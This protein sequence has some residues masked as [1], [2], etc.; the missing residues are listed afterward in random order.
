MV[1]KV[2]ASL[3]GA[4]GKQSTHHAMVRS[5]HH[6]LVPEIMGRS[7]PVSQKLKAASIKRAKKVQ[8]G[9]YRGV[10]QRPWG[11]FAAEIRD[12]NTKERKWLGTFDTAEDAALAYDT[13]ARSM[14]GPK[15]RTNFVYPTHETCLLSA[16][17]ALAAPNGNSQHHQVGLIAQKTLGEVLLLSAANNARNCNW[18]NTQLNYDEHSNNMFNAPAVQEQLVEGYRLPGYGCRYVDRKIQPASQQM[19]PPNALHSPSQDERL[20]MPKSPSINKVEVEGFKVSPGKQEQWH[21]VSDE[22]Q[23]F[24]L[25]QFKRSPTVSSELFVSRYCGAGSQ[26]FQVFDSDDISVSSENDSP[27]SDSIMLYKKASTVTSPSQALMQWQFESKIISGT[28]DQVVSKYVDSS[29][30]VNFEDTGSELGVIEPRKCLL[31]TQVPFSDESSSSIS[32]M[33]RS[34]DTASS[35]TRAAADS[36]GLFSLSSEVEPSLSNLTANEG[37]NQSSPVIAVNRFPSRNPDNLES[38]LP[39]SLICNRGYHSAAPNAEWVWDKPDLHPLTALDSTAITSRVDKVTKCD[40]NHNTWQNLCELPVSITQFLSSDSTNVMNSAKQEQL[41]QRCEAVSTMN[42]WQ[43]NLQG[44]GENLESFNPMV[45]WDIFKRCEDSSCMACTHSDTNVSG[46]CNDLY[47]LD[48]VHHAAHSIALQYPS[49]DNA[50]LFPQ[51]T[52]DSMLYV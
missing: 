31:S 49:C 22:D 1:G 29:V 11:R 39:S 9:R 40:P 51:F 17:A 23:Q 32:T 24:R 15:A 12:P 3:A 4:H 10:R 38:I 52:E 41:L 14:R 28:L 6:T 8:E 36:P 33:S 44:V 27:P 43:M 50:C 48:N 25:T 2:Q 19:P 16:A 26:P 35:P 13:A 5:S 46:F 30:I 7:R 37:C 47:M 18:K 20:V 21:C 45:D 42:Q 34:A